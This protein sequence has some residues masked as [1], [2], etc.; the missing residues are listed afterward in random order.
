M[1]N[2]ASETGAAKIYNVTTAM[3]FYCGEIIYSRHNSDFF[4]M[5][6][7]EFFL[8]SSLLAGKQQSISIVK[9]VSKIFHIFM[10]SLS[11]LDWLNDKYVAKLISDAFLHWT[12]QFHNELQVQGAATPFVRI[13]RIKNQE[14]VEFVM[15]KCCQI[16]FV[17]KSAGKDLIALAVLKEAFRLLEGNEGLLVVFVKSVL[18][19]AID[20]YHTCE[21]FA[22]A[23]K[24][25]MDL[26]DITLNSVKFLESHD[27][28]LVLDC[29]FCV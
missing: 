11:R 19:H 7:N 22:P 8:P 10:D 4:K 15:K 1:S 24:S 9:A 2:L 26:L 17:P 23:K 21:E 25:I 3:L 13:F 28:Q 27:S 29:V 12:I 18:V 5:L 16:F 14:F 20:Y 6:I